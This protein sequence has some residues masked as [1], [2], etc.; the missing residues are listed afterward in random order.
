M[1]LTH[2]LACKWV[3]TASVKRACDGP[4]WRLDRGVFLSRT[5]SKCASRARGVPFRHGQVPSVRHRG[6]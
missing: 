4:H 1:L 3:E 5:F 2:A 6:W